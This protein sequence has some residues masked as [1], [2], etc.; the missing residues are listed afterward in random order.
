MR[1]IFYPCEKV[2][3]G[4]LLWPYVAEPKKEDEL[5][6]VR[7]FAVAM[8]ALITAITSACV[9]NGESASPQETVASKHSLIGQLLLPS[10]SGSRGVEVVITVTE[11]G[12]ETRDKWILFDETG[13]FFD[14]FRGNLVGITVSTGIHAELHRIETE[15]LPEINQAGQVDVG[16]IDLRDRLTRHRLW[17]RVAEGASGGDVRMAMCFGPPPVGPKGG[18][19]ELGS[20]Q[21]PPIALGS[22]VEWLLPLE[23]QAIYFLVERP[24]GSTHDGPWRSGHQ[25]L[26]GPFDSPNLPAELI[27]D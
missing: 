6:M 22:E 12:T 26:F 10:G 18:R 21:F 1:I 9:C 20:R 27:M 14:T 15:D 25:R 13:R 23:A 7:M 11:A 2:P 4:A 5:R 17:L 19:I 8:F 16:V 24:V 3:P